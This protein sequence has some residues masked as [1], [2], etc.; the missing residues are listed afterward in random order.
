MDAAIVGGTS[1]ILTSHM[2]SVMASVGILSPEGS[3]KPF[4]ATAD[5]FGRPEAINAVFLKRFDDAV[6]DGNPIRAVIRASGT[7]A[8][9]RSS[10]GLLA[11]DTAAQADLIRKV[12][13]SAGLDPAE[14]GYIECHGTGTTQ[15]DRKETLAVA[16]IF[17][18]SGGIY[19]GSVS[20]LLFFLFYFLRILTPST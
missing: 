17:G 13:G 8:N 6:R 4:D 2:H 11:P 14:T 20:Q 3:C 19:M 5:E 15:G 7:S 1:L 16:D 9:G 18:S 12:Y 10:D